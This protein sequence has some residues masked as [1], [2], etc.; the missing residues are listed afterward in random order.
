MLGLL[1]TY[2]RNEDFSDL[3]EGDVWAILMVLTPLSILSDVDA[4]MVLS[5]PLP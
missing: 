1:S 5:A 4:R 3:F 2:P